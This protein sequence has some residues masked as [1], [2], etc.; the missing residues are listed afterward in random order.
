VQISDWRSEFKRLWQDLVPPQGQANT[1][2]G[3]L[4]RAVGKLKDEAFRNG[5]QNF[6]RS[7]LMLCKFI[8]QNLKDPKVF[9]PVELEEID[10]CIDRVLN[11]E[12]PDVSG[13][14]TCFHRLFEITVRWCEMH[15]DLI[16]RESNPTLR[17]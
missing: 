13:A 12:H 1:I 16:P 6:G 4:V 14:S 8:R 17:I 11:A 2:Q 10:K 15:P 9:S 5:N 7:H 3:E